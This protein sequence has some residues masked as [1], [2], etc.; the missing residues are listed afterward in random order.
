MKSVLALAACIALAGCAS[1]A[2]RPT[3][4]C[5]EL[6]GAGPGSDALDP[7]ATGKAVLQLTDSASVHFRVQTT[8]IGTVIATHIHRGEKGV[9][10]PMAREINPGFPGD[11][12]RGE[13]SGLPP[14]LVA[15][16]R[17]H[18]ERFYLKLHSLR[19]PG[20]AIRGQLVPC[21]ERVGQ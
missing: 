14:E 12:F 1:S 15:E 21:R 3:T 13:A 7:D 4:L 5:A 6:A 9:N 2:P 18:P 16:I 10:G 17:E 11:S 8:G 20:G 19:F